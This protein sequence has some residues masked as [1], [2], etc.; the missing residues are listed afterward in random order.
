TSNLVVS[1][2]SAS[3][4]V[5]IVD[6]TTTLGVIGNYGTA[7]NNGDPFQIEI[8][9]GVP[10]NETVIIELT[11][12]DGSYTA[13]DY[14]TIVLN[15][16]YVNIDVNDVATS[17]FGN[18]RI[19]FSDFTTF[20]GLG[21]TYQGSPLL[22]E[23]GLMIAGSVSNVV[24]NV[25]VD[26]SQNDHFSI[27]EIAQKISPTVISD[28]DVYGKFN[29]DNG[30]AAKMNLEVKQRGYAWDDVGHENYIMLEYEIINNGAGIS[31]LYAG[32]FM[33]WDIMNAV[34]NKISYNAGLKL[35]I[36]NSS[37]V[38]GMYV[39]IKLLSA[40]GVTHY[41]I[42]A[43]PGGGGGVDITDGF[44]AS[45]KYTTLTTDRPLAGVPGGGND[46]IDIL[47]SG[48]IEIFSGDSIKIT[49][50]LIAGFDQASVES[51]AINAQLMYD[52]VINP[53]ASSA[54]KM[55]VQL[56]SIAPNPASQTVQI[57]VDLS[58]YA[59]INIQIVNLQGQVIKEIHKGNLDEGKYQFTADVTGMANGVYFCRLMKDKFSVTERFVVSH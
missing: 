11:Y 47:S 54:N 6:T 32:L 17:L 35:G 12:T 15:L 3:S 37:E 13:K 49:F 55:A 31:S 22:Y 27:L 58:E 26:A 8:L 25:R 14:I 24:D 2:S 16:G 48:P 20:G 1:I 40:D 51:G 5:K 38:G 41:G 59:D 43:L 10:S 28:L 33:D 46:V 39:G 42:D 9:P 19:G 57:N 30:G 7:N 4:Y 36:T 23:G 21:F 50:A 53:T 52:A 34:Q 56:V 45:E 44:V 29:D 18:A